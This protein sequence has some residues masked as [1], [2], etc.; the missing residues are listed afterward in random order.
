[1]TDVSS[2]VGFSPR[3]QNVI[4]NCHAWIVLG[5]LVRYGRDGLLG[6]GSF[7]CFHG[8][9]VNLN[10]VGHLFRRASASECVVLFWMALV[11]GPLF[12]I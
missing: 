5:G 9:I 11:F 4:R 7:L 2:V 1:M 6:H 12:S 8:K 3:T 10:F